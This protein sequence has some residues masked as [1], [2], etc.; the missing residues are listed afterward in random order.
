MSSNT[1]LTSQHLH[2]VDNADIVIGI[3]WQ[4]VASVILYIILEGVFAPSLHNFGGSLDWELKDETNQNV[5]VVLPLQCLQ[6]F[7][8]ADYPSLRVHCCENAPANTNKVPFIPRSLNPKFNP[9][10]TSLHVTF[11]MTS[12]AA[13]AHCQSGALSMNPKK[14]KQ[15]DL[16]SGINLAAA[17]AEDGDGLVR[18]M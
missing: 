17:Q 15:S 8:P 5:L 13:D 10:I 9:S 18:K 2:V 3:S 7:F 1:Q 4:S 6:R 12:H 11:H 16:E 14:A